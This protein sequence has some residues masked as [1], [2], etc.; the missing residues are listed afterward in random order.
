[1]DGCQVRLQQTIDMQ[2]VLRTR[3]ENVSHAKYTSRVRGGLI[4]RGRDEGCNS[5]ARE[6][7][8][9]DSLV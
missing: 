5:P 2:M 6:E 8:V 1:M 3:G 7:G 9:Q 4:G